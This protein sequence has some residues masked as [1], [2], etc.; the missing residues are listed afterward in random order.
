MKIKTK[1]NTWDLI[2]LKSICTAQ[3]TIRKQKDNSQKWEKIF[4]NKGTNK[5]F[6]SK[7]IQTAYATLIKKTTQS[8]NGPK[9]QTFLQG[10]YTDGQKST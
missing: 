3:E 6:I 4:A 2:K 1:I 8:K 9:I 10:R 5:G 7:N